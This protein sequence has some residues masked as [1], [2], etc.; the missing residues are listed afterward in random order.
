MIFIRCVLATPAEPNQLFFFFR[1]SYLYLVVILDVINISH[2]QSWQKQSLVLADTQSR[3]V[4]LLAETSTCK[5][6]PTQVNF[7]ISSQ[8]C[9]WSQTL[10][11]KSKALWVR[12]SKM[13]PRQQQVMVVEQPTRQEGMSCHNLLPF[14]Y[15]I[16]HFGVMG[17]PD[18]PIQNKSCSFYYLHF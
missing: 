1:V 17:Q 5:L 11:P 16:D 12:S 10:V 18:G 9:D 2:L 6:I 15:F 13:L 4:H 3:A 14:V 8:W 7:F